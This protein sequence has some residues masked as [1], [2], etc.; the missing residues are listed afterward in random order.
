MF[1]LQLLYEVENHLAGNSVYLFLGP[2]NIR[3]ETIFELLLIIVLIY[4]ILKV[5]SAK[6]SIGGNCTP[7][8]NFLIIQM[9][10]YSSIRIGFKPFA[11]IL[12]VYR[13]N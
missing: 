10:F 3:P 4:G 13:Q 12:I 7:T 8:K 6:N 5:V 2:Q 9:C 1:I 11:I